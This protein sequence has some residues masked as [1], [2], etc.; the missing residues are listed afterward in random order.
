MDVH[1]VTSVAAAHS[2]CSQ[3]HIPHFRFH[4]E[5]DL[6]KNREAS[7]SR[8]IL[9]IYYFVDGSRV[10]G[11]NTPADAAYDRIYANQR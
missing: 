6:S 4:L 8:P 10:C 1:F 9:W 3:S 7:D 11:P 2:S 5:L